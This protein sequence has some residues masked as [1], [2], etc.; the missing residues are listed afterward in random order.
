MKISRE[1]GA[2]LK[3]KPLPDH[4]ELLYDENGLPK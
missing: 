2:R 3:G 4:G 1:C